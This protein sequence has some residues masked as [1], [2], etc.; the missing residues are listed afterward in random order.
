MK[1]E[2]TQITPDMAKEFLKRNVAD[3]RRVNMADVK[4]IAD[5]MVAGRYELLHQGIAFNLAG[6]L[7]DGQHRL[8][9]IILAGVPITMLVFFDVNGSIRSNIDRGRKRSVGFIMNQSTAWVTTVTTLRWLEMGCGALP[10]HTRATPDQLRGEYLRWHA[11]IDAFM[12]K[13]KP[14]AMSP[15]TIA[16]LIYAAPLDETIVMAFCDAV[17]DGT[18][19]EKGQPGHTLRRWLTETRQLRAATTCAWVALNAVSAELRGETLR[20]L[21]QADTGYRWVSTKRRAAKIPHTPES[22][23]VPGYTIGKSLIDLEAA[24]ARYGQ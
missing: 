19:L 7:I 18:M 6:E 16:G 24:R 1:C 20:S 21:Y 13:R 11:L 17:R 5:D 10:G 2:E 12:P 9:A 14:R 23:A 22:N 8:H 15:G 3:N 4:L